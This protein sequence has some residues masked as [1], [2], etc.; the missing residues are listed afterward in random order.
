MYAGY[1]HTLACLCL[2][3]CRVREFSKV[4]TS[5]LSVVLSHAHQPPVSILMASTP[6]KGTHSFN[7]ARRAS[8]ACVP[9]RQKHVKCDARKPVCGR[10]AAEGE[11]CQ[12][13]SSR[14]GG[15][16]RSVLAER[17]KNLDDQRQSSQAGDFAQDTPTASETGREH[18]AVNIQPTPDEGYVS[19]SVV[20]FLSTTAEPGSTSIQDLLDQG[21]NASGDYHLGLHYKH[22]HH[23]HPCVLPRIYLDKMLEQP[24]NHKRLD[25]LLS[26]MQSIGSLYGPMSQC[27]QEKIGSRISPGTDPVQ[28]AFS[29]QCLLLNS[30]VHH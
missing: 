21:W 13:L 5:I 29:V 17:R 6:R 27:H 8:L 22:F 10:C 28:D 25:L 7:A 4:A 30:I 24:V 3:D 15:L 2:P 23:T 20:V 26:V 12:L 18:E 1:Q 16:T 19:R 9:C 14:R 11:T